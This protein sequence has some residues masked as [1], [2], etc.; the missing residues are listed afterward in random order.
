MLTEIP[1]L[2]RGLN[3][4]LEKYLRKQKGFTK[5]GGLGI[6]KIASFDEEAIEDLL[7]RFVEDPETGEQFMG[8][9]DMFVEEFQ[10]RLQSPETQIY[11]LGQV[12]SYSDM[13]AKFAREHILKG[14]IDQLQKYLNN[15]DNWEKIDDVI[16]RAIYWA[17]DKILE[18]I[19]SERGRAWVQDKIGIVVHKINVTQLVEEQV[20]KLD[21][22]ELE[23][24]ILDNT[25]GNLVAIQFLGGILGLVAG[26]IQIT[27]LAAI[28][29]GIL[30][31]V[32][33]VSSV[34][35]KRKYGTK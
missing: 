10:E 8:M 15:P 16:A 17:K 6:K 28:P 20:N 12:E 1:N 7:H 2:A 33:Y 9:L 4:S 30:I 31:L 27:T 25:G 18:F 26:S 35:N 34:R 13:V 32:A 21:T 24:M 3:D 19:N 11:V 5:I 23:Q 29:V 22:D 14:G